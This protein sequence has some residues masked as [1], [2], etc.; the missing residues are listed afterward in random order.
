MKL[1]ADLLTDT[2]SSMVKFSTSGMWVMSEASNMKLL[3]AKIEY[4]K[5]AS[6]T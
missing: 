6:H 3:I 5:P 1:R 2:G 4:L